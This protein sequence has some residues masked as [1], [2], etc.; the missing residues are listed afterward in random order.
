MTESLNGS[1]EQGST[2]GEKRVYTPECRLCTHYLFDQDFEVS[3]FHCGKGHFSFEETPS[4]NTGIFP[5]NGLSDKLA[6]SGES[7]ELDVNSRW[8]KYLVK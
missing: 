8:Y 3:I 4:G 1:G 6:C 5:K 7:F 2:S